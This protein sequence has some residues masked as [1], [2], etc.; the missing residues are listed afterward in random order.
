MSPKQ[1][2]ILVLAL[3]LAFIFILAGLFGVYKYYPTYLGFPPTPEDTLS[4]EKD[5]LPYI[6]PQVVISRSELDDL[7]SKLISFDLLRVRNDSLRSIRDHLLDSLKTMDKNNSQCKDSILT[8]MDTLSN[9]AKEKKELLD[10]LEKLKNMYKKSLHENKVVRQH[11]QDLE[12][13]LASRYDSLEV[14]NFE[15][16]AK[17]YNNSKPADVARILE[18]LDERDAAKILKLMS[19]KK[20]GKVLE[21]ML[22]EHA[23]AI[24]VIGID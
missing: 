5:I 6:E 2:I 18:Q 10:S 24:L 15:T 21:E 19:K 13:M 16:F 20:A 11:V 12:E 1:L 4:K 7:Q 17:I 3:S 8:I 22:P 14:I 9:K 23:A